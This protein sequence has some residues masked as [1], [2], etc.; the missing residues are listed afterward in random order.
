MSILQPEA[1]IWYVFCWIVVGLR[2]L[3]TRMRSGSW[4]NLQ[5]DDYLVIPA[6]CTLTV[7]FAF[8]HIVI[9]T[10]NNLLAPG[11]DITKWSA[12]NF[13][14][15]VY[16]SKL[17]ISLEQMHILTIWLLKACLL[18]MYTRMTHLL[19]LQ[20]VVKLVA[21]YVAVG[22]V[23]MEVLWFAAWCRPFNQYWAVPTNST[24]CSAMIN[25]LITNAVLNIS[26][27]VMILAIP[28]PLVFKVKVP[29]KNKLVLS[30]LLFLG[31][32][33]IVAA[34]INKYSSFKDPFSSAWVIWY[35][36]EAFTAMICA[37]LPLTRPILQQF[38][39]FGEWTQPASGYGSRSHRSTIRLRSTSRS[40]RTASSNNESMFQPRMK[41]LPMA[42]RSTSQEHITQSMSPLGILYETEI[43]IERHP[44]KGFEEA[45][46]VES[47]KS[48][49]EDSDN[50]DTRS[51][52]SRP[53]SVIT[54]C[55]HEEMP[56]D[57]PAATFSQ[58]GL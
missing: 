51:V 19:Q 46:V 16:G 56:S 12:A 55:Y 36:R 41:T 54:A 53:R 42:S 7:L 31:C 14:E 18:I 25:H 13:E 39:N 1:S 50:T 22:F 58:R 49:H 21:V 28:V 48:D 8:T 33:T 32:F 20:I 29:L 2:F 17:T 15:R 5:A 11:E 24:Q 6:M 44:A 52:V 27:D 3:S 38:F 43:K 26:S 47:G 35:L 37:N 10:N 57:G 40:R 34:A 23:V 30:G 45:H 9:H 4:R